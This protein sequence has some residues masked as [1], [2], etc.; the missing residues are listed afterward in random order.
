MAAALDKT[1]FSLGINDGD[2][3]SNGRLVVLACSSS[4]GFLVRSI[5]GGRGPQNLELGDAATRFA[6]Q[7]VECIDLRTAVAYL[8]R[9]LEFFVSVGFRVCCIWLCLVCGRVRCCGLFL[10]FDC[11]VCW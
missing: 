11:I 2:R 6:R 8:V 3:C 9:R 4:D 1:G 7:L 5:L 10:Y